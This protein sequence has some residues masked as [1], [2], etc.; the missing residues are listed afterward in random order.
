[1]NECMHACSV[2]DNSRIP[3][4]ILGL[5]ENREL[6]GYRPITSCGSPFVGVRY[7]VKGSWKNRVSPWEKSEAKE[8]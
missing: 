5:E 8:L 2:V 7:T 3:S 4:V 1:M 6:K